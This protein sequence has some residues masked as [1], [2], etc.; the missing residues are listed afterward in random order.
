MADGVK[1]RLLEL[2]PVKGVSFLHN[3]W[4][5]VQEAAAPRHS[6]YHRKEWAK[7]AFLRTGALP[8]P[9][10]QPFLPFHAMKEGG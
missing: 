7:W 5:K 10:A 3:E 8:L 6:T 9:R 1:G 4:G 2:M